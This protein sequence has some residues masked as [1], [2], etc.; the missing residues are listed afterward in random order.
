MTRFLA[1]AALLASL[2]ACNTVEGVGR[3]VS[4]GGQAITGVASD[5]QRKLPPAPAPRPVYTY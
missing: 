2:A 5:V 4:A 3:D 1:A